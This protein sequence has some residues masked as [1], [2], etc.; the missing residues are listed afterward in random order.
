MDIKNPNNEA[1]NDKS[2]VILF[3][4]RGVIK[5]NNP[6]IIPNLIIILSE[7]LFIIISSIIKIKV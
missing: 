5:I 4:N 2:K 7:F 6:K 3:E 1:L